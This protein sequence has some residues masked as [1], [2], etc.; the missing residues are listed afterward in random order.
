MLLMVEK[1]EYKVEYFMQYI[2]MNNLYGRTMLQKLPVDG[3]KWRNDD[4][5]SNF[6]EK[7]IK[8]YY[9]DSEKRCILEVDVKYPKNLHDLPFFHEE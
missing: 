1:N 6:D 4:K 8:R 7:F 2:D 9:K 3:F 5:Q